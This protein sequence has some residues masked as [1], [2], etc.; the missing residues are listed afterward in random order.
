MRLLIGATILLAGN[1]AA[2]AHHSFAM[3]DHTKTLK[4]QGTVAQFEWSNPHGYIEL[5][6]IE[7]GATKHYSLETTGIPMMQR[8]GW[9]SKTVRVGDRLTAVFSPMRNGTPAGLLME[10][11]T[12]DGRSI[13]TGVPNPGSFARPD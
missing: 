11:I 10:V 9:T 2:L 5:A 12:T 8:L 4:L 6:T 13:P 3:Y 1:H 7:G